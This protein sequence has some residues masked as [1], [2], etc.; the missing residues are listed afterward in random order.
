LRTKV[1]LKEEASRA[2]AAVLAI[3]NEIY[4]V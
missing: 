1:E 2:F 3:L 4:S